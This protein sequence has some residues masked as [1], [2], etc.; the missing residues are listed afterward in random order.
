MKSFV[1][2]KKIGQKLHPE[3]TNVF[4]EQILFK[5]GIK[6]S[7][8]DNFELWS[9]PSGRTQ[10]WYIIKCT[11]NK[12]KVVREIKPTETHEYTNNCFLTLSDKIEKKS[13]QIE[14]LNKELLELKTK[15]KIKEIKQEFNLIG[16]M[17]EN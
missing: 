13:K 16:F 12:K 6:H 8:I 4:V 5:K 10:I 1:N 11:A 14:S 7:K 15:K 17:G 9:C 3:L 2:I